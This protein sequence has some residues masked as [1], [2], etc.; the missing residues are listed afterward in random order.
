MSSKQ[1]PSE[2]KDVFWLH[3]RRKTGAYPEF[4]EDGGKWLVFVPIPEV[5]SAWDKIKRATEEGKLGGSAKVSTAR[6]HENTR[7]PDSKVICVY[8]Y[9]CNDEADVKRIREELRQL[10]ITSEIPYKTDKK[11]LE[12]KYAVRGDKNIAKLVL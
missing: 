4:T 11:T 12:G 10:G 8:T 3:A 5:D 9:D 7:D 2:V 1:R 6:A